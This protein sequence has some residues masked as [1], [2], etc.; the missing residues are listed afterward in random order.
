MCTTQN[1]YNHHLDYSLPIQ[2]AA[3]SDSL[4]AEGGRM[5]LI[6]W[7]NAATVGGSFTVAGYLENEY[8]WSGVSSL[9]VTQLTSFATTVP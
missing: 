7:V 6:A 1:Q 8:R 3:Q 4:S 5:E 9:T 2:Y